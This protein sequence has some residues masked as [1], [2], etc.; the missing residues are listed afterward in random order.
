M[1]P[2]MSRF[3]TPISV[4]GMGHT[5][6]ISL[7]ADALNAAHTGEDRASI[8]ARYREPIVSLQDIDLEFPNPVEFAYYAI[9]NCFRLYAIG[10]PI[11][12]WLIVNQSLSCI[13]EPKS[14]DLR[15]SAAIEAAQE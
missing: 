3:T 5:I 8:D 14:W 2:S 6:D 9:Y 15:L 1:P 12:P 4:V 13:D 10:K 11:D 7:P